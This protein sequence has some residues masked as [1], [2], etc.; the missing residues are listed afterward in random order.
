MAKR[1]GPHPP[2]AERMRDGGVVV[3]EVQRQAA[4]RQPCAAEGE[5]RPWLPL[6]AQYAH[7]EAARAASTHSNHS[8]L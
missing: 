7:V 4:A 1:S 8:H 6:E 5:R 2:V 3:D